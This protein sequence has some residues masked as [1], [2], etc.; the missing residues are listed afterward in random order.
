MTWTTIP[1]KLAA[2]LAGLLVV[3]TPVFWQGQAGLKSDAAW[4]KAHLEELRA[5]DDAVTNE[6][7]FFSGDLNAALGS[8][9]KLNEL[10]MIATHN[11][12]QTASVPFLRALCKAGSKLTFGLLPENL[13]DFNASPLSEQLDCGIRSLEL[14][15]EAMPSADGSVRFVCEHA[16]N[17]DMHTN[18]YDFSLALEEI[19]L[20]SKH[21]PG[22][23][24]IL[25][26]VEPKFWFLPDMTMDYFNLRYANAVDDLLREQLGD[27]LSTPRDVLRGYDD[28]HAMRM[29]D[30]WPAVRDLCGKVLV[31]LHDTLTVS[32]RYIS[33]DRTLRSQ[34]MFPLLRLYDKDKPCAA[35]LMENDPEKVVKNAAALFDDGRYIVRTRADS[36]ANVREGTRSAA[37]VCGAQMLSTDYPP[38]TM[39]AD[40]AEFSFDGK[41][42]RRVP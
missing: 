33:Q 1:A 36:F 42:L 30:D 37:L 2:L 11:S 28:F 39:A 18:S 17:F 35:F 22:H 9:I 3:L 23:L 41:T 20:W 15:I 25:L 26:I 4:Q 21:H 29:A 38:G 34:A 7:A 27:A 14:D 19:A 31:L 16:P 32:P 10:Q 24:P 40:A 13:C 8:G 6:A 12:Y 5:A